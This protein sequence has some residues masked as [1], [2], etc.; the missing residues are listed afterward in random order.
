MLSRSIQVLKEQVITGFK[1]TSQPSDRC[2]GRTHSDNLNYS[3]YLSRVLILYPRLQP[4]IS[5]PI[6]L[7]KILS[8]GVPELVV[9]LVGL[10]IV[11][12]KNNIAKKLRNL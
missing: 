2:N 6:W 1:V 5:L 3:D 12:I 10:P 11:E 4:V 8:I 9:N 7:T